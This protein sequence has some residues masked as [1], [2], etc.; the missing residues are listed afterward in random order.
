[1]YTTADWRTVW[2]AA[3]DCGPE[4]EACYATGQ[5]LVPCVPG[6]ANSAQVCTACRDAWRSEHYWSEALGEW[7]PRPYAIR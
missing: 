3:D 6:D 5:P 7:I 1:M 4:C 2:E